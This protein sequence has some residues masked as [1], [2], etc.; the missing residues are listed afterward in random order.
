MNSC[1]STMKSHWLM[2]ICVAGETSVKGERKPSCLDCFPVGR[3]MLCNWCVWFKC[4][5][6]SNIVAV[7]YGDLI[8]Y[9]DGRS[10]Q[11]LSL[12]TY[13]CP[14]SEEIAVLPQSLRNRQGNVDSTMREY[15]HN[16]QKHHDLK[17]LK[18]AL[19]ILSRHCWT[20]SGE[21]ER[22][23]PLLGLSRHHR[24]ISL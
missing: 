4:T 1:L 11:W 21:G 15:M 16:Y 7:S 19:T 3:P 13:D 20:I 22:A 2:R 18:T 5:K 17:V 23:P 14:K 9:Q 10:A 24:L 6:G 12:M 8:R